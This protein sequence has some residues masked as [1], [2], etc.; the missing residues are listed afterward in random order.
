MTYSGAMSVTP[1]AR[2]PYH[3]GAEKRYLA[4]YSVSGFWMPVRI[5]LQFLTPDPFPGFTSISNALFFFFF[6]FWFLKAIEEYELEK[7]SL[8]EKTHGSLG[9]K[10]K[11]IL[12][13]SEKCFCGVWFFILLS[14]DPFQHFCFVLARIAGPCTCQA[15]ALPLRKTYYYFL[16]FEM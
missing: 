10:G 7:K 4:T 11:K 6:F 1:M 8:K 12:S 14:L 9:D 5:K 13:Q 3:P 16:V 15:H 2:G